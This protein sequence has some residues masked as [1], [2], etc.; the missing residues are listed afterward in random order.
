M[1]V[2]RCYT[3]RRGVERERREVRHS[4]AC[5]SV[6]IAHALAAAGKRPGESLQDRR[7][8]SALQRYLI[9]FGLAAPSAAVVWLVFHGVFTNLTQTE[10]AMGYVD[11]LTQMGIYLGYVAMFGGTLVFVGVAAWA[12]VRAAGIWLGRRK[13]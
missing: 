6:P 7:S 2:A 4:V 9:I 1:P 10:E 3:A 12:A 8:L 13:E 11:P 5:D